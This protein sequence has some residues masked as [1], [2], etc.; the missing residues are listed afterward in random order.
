[1]LL[2]SCREDMQNQPRYKPLR[3]SDFYADGRSARPLV[4][5]TVAR[6]E[7]VNDPYFATGFI[8]QNPG[9]YMPFAVTRE[10]LQRGQ[11]RFNIFCAPCHSRVGDG[12]GMVVQRGF[13]RPPSYHIDRLRKEPLG[14]F[15]DVISNGFG[16]M[17]DHA[18]QIPAADRWAV[19]AYIRALQMSQNAPVSAVP[20]GTRLAPA[21]SSRL[22]DTSAAQA[23]EQQ[24]QNKAKER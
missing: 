24:Q 15:F 20:A 8:G 23:V 7:L 19:V 2:S 4:A 1:L 9:D 22:G 17:P 13:Q 21:P 16:A 18:E 11:E 6:E 10:V 5:G 3:R 14:H 12:N